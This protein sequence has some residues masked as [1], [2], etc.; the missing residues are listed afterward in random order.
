MTVVVEPADTS[1]PPEA[2]ALPDAGVI[3]DARLRQ[4][5]R[6]RR[7]AAVAAGVLVASALLGW[8]TGRF[9]ADSRRAGGHG[10]LAAFQRLRRERRLLGARISP[11]LEGGSY[12]WSVIES[13]GAGCCTLPQES[14]GGAA[15]GAIA[16]WTGNS[17]EEA[18]TALLSDRVTGIVVGDQRAHLVTLA[19]LPYGLRIAEIR[20]SRHS[21]HLFGEGAPALLALGGHS[22]RI[23]Y[24]P[25]PEGVGTVVRWWQK[26]QPL[27]HGPCQ[28]LARGVAGLEPE[29]G[30][31]AVAIRPYPQRIMGR[32]FFSCIDSEYYLHNW[33]LDAA[34]LLDAQQPGRTPAPIPGMKP[35]P[36]AP[37]VFSA[38][39]DWHGELTATRRGNAWLAVAGGSGPTQRIQVVRHLSVS[40]A[41]PHG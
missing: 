37:G 25:Q 41:L 20:F 30:H 13:D 36:G 28:L 24:M 27:P 23:G 32:A 2:T 35:V 39:G 3:V 14:A 33:P 5:R 1:G 12:G 15:I 34:I 29:W 11:A 16:G 18:A 40:I 17:Y 6:R 8:A 19:R 7:V 22:K 9:G 10:N 38:P 21:R 31:V 26:P 4:L